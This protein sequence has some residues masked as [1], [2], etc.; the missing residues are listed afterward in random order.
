[1]THPSDGGLKGLGG[2]SPEEHTA[3]VWQES[4]PHLKRLESVKIKLQGRLT[5]KIN[6]GLS[7]T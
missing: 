3:A 2:V 7:R 6:S 5:T 1:M 4:G